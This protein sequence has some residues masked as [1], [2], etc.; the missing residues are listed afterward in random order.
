MELYRSLTREDD[1][2]HYWPDDTERLADRMAVTP[3]ADDL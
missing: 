1:P 2:Q 3:R